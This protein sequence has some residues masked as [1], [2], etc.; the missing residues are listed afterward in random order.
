MQLALCSV[1][2]Q[3]IWHAS[4][5][6]VFGTRAAEAFEVEKEAEEEA[7]AEN[8]AAEDQVEAPNTD[9]KEEEVEVLNCLLLLDWADV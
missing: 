4:P 3:D 1:I 8:A 2:D 9:C 6:P 5:Q 7:A